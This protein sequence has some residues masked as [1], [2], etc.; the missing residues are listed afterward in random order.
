M[1]I[2]DKIMSVSEEIQMKYIYVYIYN[3]NVFY[4]NILILDYKYLGFFG[5]YL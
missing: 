1:C 4:I 5:R 3:K 2:N